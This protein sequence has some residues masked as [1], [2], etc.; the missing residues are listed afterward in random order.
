LCPRSNIG[1]TPTRD[2]ATIGLLLGFFGFLTFVCWIAVKVWCYLF[3]SAA[4]AV[5]D[6]PRA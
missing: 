6:E 4:H 5:Q 1:K 3:R 2:F